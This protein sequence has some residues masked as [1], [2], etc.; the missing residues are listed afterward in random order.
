MCQQFMIATPLLLVFFFSFRQAFSTALNVFIG[1]ESNH[2]L[3]SLTDWLTHSL[4]FSK[5]DWYDPGMW[6]LKL[7]KVLTIAHV[8]DEKRV[9]NSLVQIWKVKFGHKVQTLSTRFQ[10]LVK[11]LKVTF[12]QDFEAEVWSLFCYWCLVV[13]MKFNL[14]RDSKARFGQDF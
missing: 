1:T 2:W 8:D 11:I 7:V 12:R 6:Q 10:G 3:C 9:D 5:L 4:L 13:V 14:G